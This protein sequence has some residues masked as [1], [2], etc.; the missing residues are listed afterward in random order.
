MKSIA[1][2]IRLNF[3]ILLSTGPE[4]YMFCYSPD[5]SKYISFS[6][7]DMK[8]I[9]VLGSVH[10]TILEVSEYIRLYLTFFTV[11]IQ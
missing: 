11:N 2:Q 4:T 7:K 5:Y 8:I 9:Y 6:P 3:I 1:T 10:R